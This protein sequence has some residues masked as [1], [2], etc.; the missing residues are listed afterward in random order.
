[1]TGDKTHR[2]RMIAMSERNAGIGC[3]AAG[4]SDTRHDLERH[5][6]GCQLLDLLATAAKD[7]RITALEP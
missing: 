2:L 6:V 1:M 4:G 7:E 3:T 5:T